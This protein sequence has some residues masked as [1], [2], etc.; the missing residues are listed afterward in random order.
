METLAAI[1]SD[2]QSAIV[3]HRYPA[4]MAVENED[5]PVLGRC[6][7]LCSVPDAILERCVP[8]CDFRVAGDRWIA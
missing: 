5:F 1:A 2:D 3:I 7:A 4:H 6:R 8:L